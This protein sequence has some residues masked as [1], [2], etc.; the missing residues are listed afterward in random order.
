MKNVLESTPN[1]HF[2]EINIS[3]S[4]KMVKKLEIVIRYFLN[5]SL[6]NFTKRKTNF[7]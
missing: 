1:E 6:F 3:L 7:Y 5:D 4:S 2:M